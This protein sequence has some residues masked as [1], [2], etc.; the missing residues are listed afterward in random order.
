MV[1]GLKTLFHAYGMYGQSFTEALN[2]PDRQP[3]TKSVLLLCSD[4][5]GISRV[6]LRSLPITA[7]LLDL[8]L[9]ENV[10]ATPSNLNAIESYIKSNRR[11]FY[12]KDAYDIE[13]LG[14]YANWDMAEGSR[15]LQ[16][17]AMGGGHLITRMM[18]LAVLALGPTTPE[19]KAY[20]DKWADESI[21]WHGAISSAK[22]AR[23]YALYG[24]VAKVKYFQNKALKLQTSDERDIRL[25]LEDIRHDSIPRPGT[26]TDGRIVGRLVLRTGQMAP[27]RIGLF[28]IAPAG[29]K[30]PL[31][32]PDM[33]G[34]AKFTTFIALRDAKII[35]KD[36]QFSFANV[37]E[38][39][40]CLAFMFDSN[41]LPLGSRIVVKNNPGYFQIDR[42]K[43]IKDLHVISISRT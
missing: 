6:A 30:P 24:D 29:S 28:C 32:S 15:W 43:P 39:I 10:P 13:A 26:L 7:Q 1:L 41:K 3:Q 12:L 18:A 33:G 23:I 37:R 40:Y 19:Q 8:Y 20:L 2:L 17:A 4:D 21:W 11:T 34:P 9:M 36:L 27:E 35:R 14:H 42:Q 16:E 25:T 22:L 38:G 31:Q 5:K